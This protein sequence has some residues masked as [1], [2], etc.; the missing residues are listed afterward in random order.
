[1]LKA[2]EESTK[3]DSSGFSW[4]RRQI[5]GTLVAER[6]VNTDTRSTLAEV[7]ATMAWA[8][9]PEAGAAVS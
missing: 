4:A 9:E 6:L 7:A 2:L 8:L 3:C 5:A 1:M